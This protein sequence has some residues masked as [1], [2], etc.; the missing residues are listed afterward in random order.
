M[1]LDPKHAAPFF[2]DNPKVPGFKNGSL[3]NRYLEPYNREIREFV[4]RHHYGLA[5]IYREIS[6]ETSKGNWDLRIRADEGNPADDK[7]H[8]RDRSWFDNIH[9]NGRGTEVIA[10]LYARILIRAMTKK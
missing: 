10:N 1:Y 3:R 7:I 9:P 6:R 8:K 4:K 2:Q 5:D